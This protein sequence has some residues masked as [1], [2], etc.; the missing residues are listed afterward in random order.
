MRRLICA[1]LIAVAAVCMTARTSSANLI[2]NGDFEGTTYSLDGDALP[3]GWSLGP[4]SNSALSKVNVTNATGGPLGPQSGSSYLRYQSTEN[5]GSEDCVWEDI[6]TVAGQQYI[7]SYYVA[8]TA[9]TSGVQDFHAAWD[10]SNT[11]SP[12]YTVHYFNNSLGQVGYQFFSTV[13]TASSN[14]TRLD[15][16]AVDPS[17]S[18]LLDNVSVTSVPEPASVSLLA[19]GVLA[20]RRRRPAR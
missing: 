18:F 2:V 6:P 19:A 15:F 1:S 13:E 14:L 11:S 9:A 17:G 12:D 5:D 20:L 4:P 7:L 8:D 3:T 16:H 10:E